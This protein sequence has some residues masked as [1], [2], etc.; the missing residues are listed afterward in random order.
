MASAIHTITTGPPQCLL[1]MLHSFHIVTLCSSVCFISVHVYVLQLVESALKSKSKHLSW[2]CTVR[3]G[4]A[5]AAVDPFL[6]IGAHVPDWA[7]AAVS[8]TGFLHTGSSI[9]T[10]PISACHGTDLTVLPVETLRACT[11]VIVLQILG[12]GT[13]E[14]LKRCD[15]GS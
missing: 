8:S 7:A 15:R 2:F 12:G 1:F 5:A 4:V 11:R 10:R 14:E 9:K 13:K 6:A 3:A